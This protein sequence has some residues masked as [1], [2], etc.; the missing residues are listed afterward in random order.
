MS[1]NASTSPVEP[2][3]QAVPQARKVDVE[4][5]A[6]DFGAC[7]RCVATLANIEEA[8]EMVQQVLDV[9]GTEVRVHKILVE[10]EEQA[11]RHRFA[12]SPTIRINGHD[13]AS[14]T[15]ESFCDSCTDLCGCD[16]GMGCRVWR[17][18]GQEYTEAP[19]GARRRSNPARNL[20]RNHSNRF[21]TYCLRRCPR[22]SAA[23]LRGKSPEKTVT[24]SLCCTPVEQEVCCKP[25]AKQ[26]CCGRAEVGRCGCQ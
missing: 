12:T 26:S 7:T 17:Y 14:E 24:A 8:I 19:V 23:L 4:L 5:L 13:L 25:P 3:S 1:N 18:Q 10:S 2:A 21:G 9:T 15:L 11:R 22:E 20:R 16:E 6:L